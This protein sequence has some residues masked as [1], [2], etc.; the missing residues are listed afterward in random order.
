MIIAI[1][2]ISTVVAIVGVFTLLTWKKHK[3]AIISILIIFILQTILAFVLKPKPIKFKVSKITIQELT[4]LKE[5]NATKLNKGMESVEKV[6]SAGAN[7]EATPKQTAS[8]PVRTRRRSNVNNQRKQ[9]ANNYVDSAKASGTALDKQIAFYKIAI[10]FNMYNLPAWYGLL[11]SYHE[12][13]DSDGMQETEKQMRDIF[14]DEVN[15]VNTAVAQYGE[16][17]DAYVN[18]SGAYR[19]EFKTKKTS[20]DDI[21]RDVFNLTRAVRN[22]CNCTN[23]SVYASTGPASGLIAHSTAATSV[24]TLSEFSQQANILWFD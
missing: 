16:I 2:I 5:E 21:L 12:K 14:G 6:S 3:V 11:Q 15:S 7:I 20:K 13:K 23:I 1:F 24:H 18:E 10:S 22:S 4:K 17:M 19:V 8:D 9:Q